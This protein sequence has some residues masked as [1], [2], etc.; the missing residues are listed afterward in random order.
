MVFEKLSCVQNH[1]Q[2]LEGVRYKTT[3]WRLGETE[4]FHEELGYWLWDSVDKQV[5]RCFMIPRGVTVIAGG[6]C[7][8]TAKSFE[9]KADVGSHTYGICSNQFLDRE[10]KT[11]HYDLKLSVVGDTLTYEEDTHVKMKDR[12]IFHHTDKNT[13]KRVSS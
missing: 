13:L 8:P 5:I 6:T 10:F 4:P 9:L 12:P 1:E 7:E 3:A 11:V 2:R